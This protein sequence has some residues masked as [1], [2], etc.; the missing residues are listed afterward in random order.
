[1]L[2]NALNE[3]QESLSLKRLQLNKENDEQL[4]LAVPAE[5]KQDEEPLVEPISM[6]SSQ[7]FS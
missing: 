6:T 1:M 5:R 2:T 3:F 4:P 7:V